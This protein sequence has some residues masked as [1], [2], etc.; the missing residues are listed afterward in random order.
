M[1]RR[2]VPSQEDF[3]RAKAAMNK[4][5]QGLADVRR[6]IMTQFGSRGVH[7]VLILYSRTTKSFGVFVFLQSNT[8]VASAHESGLVSEIEDAALQALEDVGR[9]SKSSLD[10]RFELDSDE[11]VQMDFAGNY[12]H[13]LR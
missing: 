10:V 2:N 11:N 6:Q 13:R 1:S 5:D 9:G 7:Q 12:Y 3:A 4:D 8:Q